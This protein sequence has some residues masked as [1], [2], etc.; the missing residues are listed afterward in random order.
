MAIVRWSDPFRELAHLQER[1]NRVFD[2]FSRADTGRGDEG[3][4]TSGSWVPPVE[5]AVQ[6]Q[7]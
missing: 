1:M 6:N 5:S 3:L 7:M 4:L 2:H